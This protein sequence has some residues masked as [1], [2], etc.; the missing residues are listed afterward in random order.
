MNLLKSFQRQP[1]TKTYSL[2]DVGQSLVKVAIVLVTP[3]EVQWV[4]HASAVTGGH[5]IAGGRAEAEAILAAVNVALTQAEDASEAVMGHKIVPDEVIFALPNRATIGQLFIIDQKRLKPHEPISAKELTKLK[6]TAQRSAEKNWRESLIKEKRWQPVS[7]TES[8]WQ[9]DS[10]LVLQGLGLK[11]RLVT[12]SLFG[13][14]VEP[15]LLRGLEFLAE[16]LKLNIHQMVAP[17]QALAHLVHQSAALILDVGHAGTGVY[18]IRNSELI[19]TSWLPLGGH[20]FTQTLSQTAELKPD[21]AQALQRAWAANELAAHEVAWLADHLQEPL[22]RWYDALMELLEELTED[23]PL[24][25][26]VY[27]TGG[28]SQLPALPELLRSDPT[29]FDGAPECYYFGERPFMGFKNLAGPLDYAQF[30]VTV[31]LALGIRN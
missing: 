8:A 29:L 25:R 22:Y 17:A 30:A 12:I 27:L 9:V 14:A 16:E 21:M 31:G 7:M 3:H 13:V 1:A 19:M 11:G 20:F 6:Q 24:P 28:G 2:I 23:E 26:R 10:H 5:D 18:L 4:S 15:P